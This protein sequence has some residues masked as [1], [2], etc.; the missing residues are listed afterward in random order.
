MPRST[1]CAAEGGAAAGAARTCGPGGIITEPDTF[2]PSPA[3]ATPLGG[4][5]LQINDAIYQATGFGNTFMVV[6]N[7]GNV[8]IDTSISFLAPGHKAGAARDRRRS[9]PLHHPDARTRRPHRRRRAVETGGHRGHRAAAIRPSSS[10]TKIG[11][12]PLFLH[13]NLA[14]F[15]L[16]FG[17]TQLPPFAP[18]D[19]PVENDGGQTFADP[20]LRPLLRVQARRAHFPDVAHTRRD[21]R[22]PDGVD[23]RVQDR[24]SGRQLLRL[25][26]QPLHAARHPAASGARLRAPRSTRS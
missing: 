26:S 11:C 14:Q 24:L 18:P 20:R 16:L 7:E 19:A 21:S 4:G 9:G 17:V 10:T 22:P 8:I 13:R 5:V 25:V 1:G 6:T 2:I 3:A 23:P 12:A 15:S